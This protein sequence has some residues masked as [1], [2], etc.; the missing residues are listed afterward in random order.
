M[1]YLNSMN[2][3]LKL[4][5]MRNFSGF[6]YNGCGVGYS[7]DELF[8]LEYVNSKQIF[9][10]QIIYRIRNNKIESNH[11]NVEFF[12]FINGADNFTTAIVCD[13][14]FVNYENDYD[15]Q[16]LIDICIDEETLPFGSNVNNLPS[17]LNDVKDSN[18]YSLY[19]NFMKKI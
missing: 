5:I 10:H 17:I 19:L 1:I 14:L 18:I 11:Y 4:F 3:N 12:N 16:K 7:L 6:S 9:L 8:G 2:I 15:I 13:R